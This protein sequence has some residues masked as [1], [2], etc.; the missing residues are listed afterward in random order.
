[1]GYCLPSLLCHINFGIF[2]LMKCERLH[3]KNI[4]KEERIS[5]ILTVCFSS[6]FVCSLRCRQF[7]WF[8][9]ECIEILRKLLAIWFRV[10]S[11]VF[12]WNYACTRQIIVDILHSKTKR[13]M[14]GARKSSLNTFMR[15]F[16]VC[17]VAQNAPDCRHELNQTKHIIVERISM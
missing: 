1:M 15:Q 17:S 5:S 16:Q 4:E 10:D 8:I 3:D 13:N 11:L 14:C 2:K 9:F 12:L 7:V 6:L